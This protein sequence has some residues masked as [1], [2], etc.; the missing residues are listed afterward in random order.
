MKVLAAA[1]LLLSAVPAFAD[2]SEP[3]NLIE[4]NDSFIGGVDRH[5]TQ[6]LQL[7]Q[8]FAPALKNDLDMLVENFMLP[9]GGNTWRSGWFAGQTMY[10]PENLVVTNPSSTDR[11]YA[12]WL[13]AGLRDYRYDDN[14]LDK[15][16][17]TLGTTGPASMAANVQS[18]WHAMG[19]FGGLKP[20]GWHYQL[21]D[22][23]GLILSGQRIWRVTLSDSDWPVEAEILPEAN[24]SV[25]NVFDY[26]A[27]G[28]M[29]RIGQNLKADWGPPRIQPALSG[30]D[31]QN[32]DDVA[33]YAFAGFEG[34]AV[35]RNLFLDGNSF[36]ASRSVQKYNLVSEIDAGVALQF[37]AFRLMGSY[38]RRSNEFVYQR[39]NDQLTSFTLTFNL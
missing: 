6:G 21:H 16:E 33:W 10:T 30:A 26:A 9:D 23:P 18:W 37:P 11:P 25:G 35:G 32:V 13:F 28:G 31:F 17:I 4:E 19:L 39:G 24:V 22:E 36:G 14:V 38:S 8:T 2:I 20:K 3:I 5:Y 1:A 15:A 34:R 29:L 7:S 27:A 12:G